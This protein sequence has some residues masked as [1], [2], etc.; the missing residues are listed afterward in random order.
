MVDI[1]VIVP[2]YNM[3]GFLRETLDSIA[4][5]TPSLEAAGRSL[6]VVVI[7]DGSR[8]GSLR[9]AREYA[10]SHP[11]V[12]VLSQ[13][14]RGLAAARNRA[15]S[16]ARGRYLFPL[17]ADDLLGP[18]FLVGAAEVLD[19]RPEVKVVSGQNEFFGDR[20]GA[21]RLPDFSLELLARRN[22]ICASA[23]YRRSD[24]ERAGGYCEQ[25][26]CYEDWDFWIAVL[27]DG[28]EVVR[29]PRPAIRYRIRGGSMRVRGRRFKREVV[30]TLNARHGDFFE[31][32][33]CG[34]LRYHRTWSRPWNR[35]LRLL[36]FGR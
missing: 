10:A 32:V 35:L 25:I 14:N 20:T 15:I 26:V 4:A 5:A 19:R 30:D 13:P 6:E 21:W 11:S 34:P 12:R 1:S 17:D 24:W 3:E 33:L 22:L 36:R 2:V 8:D 7:D 27:K 23:L 31:R 29:L 9:L 18:D 28:G 16:E